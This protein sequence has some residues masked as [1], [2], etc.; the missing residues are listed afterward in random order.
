MERMWINQPSTGQPFHKWHAMNVLARPDTDS[1]AMQIYFLDGVVIS[2]QI[3]RNCLSKGW[4][5]KR[6]PKLDFTSVIEGIA[7]A[8]ESLGK[9]LTEVVAELAFAR[10]N[11]N[12]HN[13]AHEGYAV[14]LEEVDELW[15]EVKVNQKRRDPAKMRKEA[16][17]VAA[18]AIRFAEECCDEVSCRR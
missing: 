12:P 2:Q 13:S 15:T 1:G 4:I 18:M 5:P 16:I 8:S 14:L 11:F 7:K 6:D 3:P 10:A 9:T 17:Q